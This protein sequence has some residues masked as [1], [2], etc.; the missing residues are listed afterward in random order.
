M[1]DHVRN[2]FRIPE[3]R[4][5]LI[6]TV[7]MVFIY[8]VGAFIPV[9]GV[10][11]TA[12]HKYVEDITGGAGGG[13]LDFVD[14]FTGGALSNMAIFAMGIMPY[15]SASIILQLLTVMVPR[16][17]RLAKEGEVGRRKINRYT[18]YLTAV[19]GVVQAFAIS[20]V[21]VSQKTS[22][23]LKLVPDSGV[24]F[25]VNTVLTLTA[26]T[27][28]IMWLGEQISER[29]VGNGISLLICIGIISRFPA[30]VVQTAAKVRENTLSVL[31][32]AML[33]LMMVAIIAFIIFVERAQRRIPVQYAKRVIGNR[34]RAGQQT[35]LPLKLNTSGVIPVV[36]A[37]SV[38]ILPSMILQI[39]LIAQAGWANSVRHQLE[40]AMP[41]Y[42]LFYVA[43]IV[44][45]SFFYTSIAFN[46]VDA[47][48]N[49][50]K[51]GGFIPGIRPGKKTA[52][53]IDDV[54]SKITFWGALYLSTVSLIPMFLTSGVRLHELPRWMGGGLFNNMPAWFKVGLDLP[55]AAQS[56]FGG[57]SL[58]IVVGVCM[59]FM[60]QIESQLIMRNYD[61]FLRG[62][63]LRGRRG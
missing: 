14:M 8:R 23:G 46:P 62:A 27:V 19:I 49:I 59:D 40:P 28:F 17:E 56:F 51:Y 36:F 53:Y 61:G 32:L 35:H 5:R 26:G 24:W 3:L 22:T 50:K 13:A 57:T 10:D 52:E 31:E 39:P 15:V 1:I 44:F 54:L 6:Y 11:P 9:P 63:R 29:G 33:I 12:L 58:L 20:M 34:V 43:L 4:K 2:A 48:D 47:T 60:A 42:M 45:F 37:Q 55:G 38:I 41:G 30:G 25:H 7:L 16:L 21:L 18:R